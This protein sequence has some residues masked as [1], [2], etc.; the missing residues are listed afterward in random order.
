MGVEHWPLTPDGGPEKAVPLELAADFPAYAGILLTQLE[1]F[2]IPFLT[3]RPG[4][5]ELGF[6][7]GGFSP[8]GIQVYVPESR[9]D[10]AKAILL[11]PPAEDGA[12]T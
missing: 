6:L 9:L 4:L 10:E 12:T 8:T 3:D 5:G 11:A 2:G 1:A 7:Y